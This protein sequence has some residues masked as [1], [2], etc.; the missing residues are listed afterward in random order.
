VL[1]LDIIDNAVREQ[2][3]VVVVAFELLVLQT[4][5]PGRGDRRTQGRTVSST[6]LEEFAEQCKVLV[7]EIRRGVAKFRGAPGFYEMDDDVD[8]DE[9]VGDEEDGEEGEEVDD[10]EAWVDPPDDEE[11]WTTTK[12]GNFF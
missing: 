8:D 6:G 7:S 9:V 2:T 5:R 3:S 12:R 10:E 1:L 4:K 11:A